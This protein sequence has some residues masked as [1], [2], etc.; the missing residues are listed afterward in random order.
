[1]QQDTQQANQINPSTPP[2]GGNPPA[3]ASKRKR[4]QVTRHPPQAAH[5]A[6]TLYSSN[7]T[8]KEAPHDEGERSCTADG[9][10][11]DPA[12]H[13]KKPRVGQVE[14]QD[15]DFKISRFQDDRAAIPRR[16]GGTSSPDDGISGEAS[17]GEGSLGQGSGSGGGGSRCHF[18]T[19][20]Q[21]QVDADFNGVVTGISPQAVGIR[22]ARPSPKGT[23]TQRWFTM[24]FLCN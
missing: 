8:G 11:G 17:G 1:M 23:A 22:G 21:R 9:N 18:N 4:G 6:A 24:Q 16:T 13:A 20:F 12:P 3:A 19:P 14:Q 2:A 15:Q 7:H 5:S 10:S